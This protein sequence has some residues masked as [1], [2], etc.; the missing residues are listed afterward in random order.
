MNAKRNELTATMGRRRPTSSGTA[1][2]EPAA[3][4]VEAVERAN[5]TAG[6]PYP[7]RVA[8]DLSEEQLRW[9]RKAHLDDGVPISTRARA[10][11]AIC[12][13]TPTLAEEARAVALADMA[14]R[15]G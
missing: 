14:S 3:T 12:M 15:R 5:W 7:K 6:K 8:L 4:P 9:L 10:L 13:A 1:P 2:A 11:V